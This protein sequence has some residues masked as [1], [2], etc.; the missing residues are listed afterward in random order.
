MTVIQ[1]TSEYQPL[2]IVKNAGVFQRF[3]IL[4]SANLFPFILHSF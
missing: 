1:K 2:K 4:L 3:L